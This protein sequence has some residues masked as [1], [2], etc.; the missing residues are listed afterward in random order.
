[1]ELTHVYDVYTA[2]D[3]F[4]KVYQLDGSEIRDINI[5]K[6]TARYPN[7]FNDNDAINR[8]LETERKIL[9]Q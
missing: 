9:E 1:V 4:Q 5:A 8:N 6:L 3:L 7:A 2:L